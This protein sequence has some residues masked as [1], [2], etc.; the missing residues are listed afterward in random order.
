MLRDRFRPV[1]VERLGWIV[2][3]SD[4]DMG[5]D[6][7]SGV[8]EDVR[9]G[10][11]CESV[12]LLGT[13]LRTRFEGISD[14]IERDT[15]MGLFGSYSTIK[16]ADFGRHIE[17]ETRHPSHEASVGPSK[18]SLAMPDHDKRCPGSYAG[19]DKCC[20]PSHII[21]VPQLVTSNKVRLATPSSVQRVRASYISPVICS[22]V[23][24]PHM[25]L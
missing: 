12:T 8:C 18:Y 4:S 6:W 9:R 21:G 2:A 16:Q 25:Q 1:G 11:S 7:V 10:R 14:D 20:K 13:P 5:W 17:C 19:G 15:D 3:G 22:L 24:P 23:H